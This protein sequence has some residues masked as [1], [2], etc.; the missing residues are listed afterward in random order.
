MIFWIYLIDDNVMS[1]K[2]CGVHHIELTVTD[3]NKSK[4]FYSELLG[5]KLVADYANFAMFYNGYFYLGLTDHKGNCKEKR[6]DERNVGMD[7]ISFEVKSRKDLEQALLLFDKEKIK[8]GEIKKLS[9]NLYV[10]AFR[11]PDNIQLELS[12]RKNDK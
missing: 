11:D 1:I 12:W 7:H 8:H 10:L 6:F 9:N 5:F 3:I 4:K 2:I